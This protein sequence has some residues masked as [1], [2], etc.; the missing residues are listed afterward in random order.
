M[1]V[2]IIQ[3]QQAAPKKDLLDYLAQGIGAVGGLY[4]IS[5]KSKENDILSK[6]QQQAQ[7]QMDANAA[8][9][10]DMT[11]PDNVAFQESVK[12]YT[13][14]HGAPPPPDLHT[15]LQVKQLSDLK[16]GYL[17]AQKET[18]GIANT[19]ATTNKTNYEA[20]VGMPANTRKTNLESQKIAQ[21]LGQNMTPEA[22]KGLLDASEKWNDASSRSELGQIKAN[23]RNAETIKTLSN[24]LG[25]D[26]GKN[27]NPNET[28]EQRVAR[29]NSADPRQVA[30]IVKS[31]DRMLSQGNPTISGQEHLTPTTFEGLSQKFGEKVLNVPKGANQGQFIDRILETVDREHATNSQMRDNI[32]DAQAGAFKQL[33][34]NAADKVDILANT[35][36]KSIFAPKAYTTTE[37]MGPSAAAKA[38]MAPTSHGLLEKFSNFMGATKANAQTSL[39][40]KDQEA[41]Q[42]AN[43]NPKDP[44]AAQIR[45]RLGVK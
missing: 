5:K 20:N 26:H 33:Y 22:R 42:W 31:L 45:N 15:A 9:Q 41:L 30:E 40:S 18:A 7:N 13:A 17:P 27:A 16:S 39:T 25:V 6:N 10:K 28:P 23:I 1:P 14:T 44:R 35:S 2:S 34:P 24:S 38:S 19:Q 32:I 21:E 43:S 29:Y 3:R 11:T 4:D 36:K 12:S 37:Q 8:I